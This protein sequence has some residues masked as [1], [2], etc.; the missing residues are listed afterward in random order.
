MGKN[1]WTPLA[2]RVTLAGDAQVRLELLV[3]LT[4]ASM[5]DGLRSDRDPL[6]C[7]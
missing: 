2:P 7:L 6:S 5:V 4:I 3:R 1:D